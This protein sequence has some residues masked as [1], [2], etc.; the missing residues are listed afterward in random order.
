MYRNATPIRTK[1]PEQIEVGR[2]DFGA[3]SLLAHN[4][5]E[6]WLPMLWSNQGSPRRMKTQRDDWGRISEQGIDGVDAGHNRRRS[7]CQ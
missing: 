2:D 1:I 4:P 3:I 5:K 7:R 6:L